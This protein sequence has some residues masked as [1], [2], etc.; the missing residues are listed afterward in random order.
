MP[1]ISNNSNHN[2]RQPNR[3]CALRNLRHVRVAL[4]ASDNQPEKVFEQRK[5]DDDK[6]FKNERESDE[7]SDVI[8]A[9]V[10][11]AAV[12]SLSLT[13]GGQCSARPC[14]LRRSRRR[15]R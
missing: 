9:A 14:A 6:K 4:L 5:T 11:K 8:I 15:R 12:Q 7:E 2:L 13:F 1:S 3:P 10:I